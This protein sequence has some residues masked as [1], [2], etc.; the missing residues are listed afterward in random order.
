MNVKF[1]LILDRNFIKQ[2]LTMYY[3][4]CSNYKNTLHFFN[5]SHMVAETKSE[6]K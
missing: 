6:I 5:P 2:K 4:G 1:G 3:R